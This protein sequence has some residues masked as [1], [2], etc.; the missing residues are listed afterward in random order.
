MTDEKA[1]KI[2]NFINMVDSLSNLKIKSNGRI[3]KLFELVNT[4]INQL[5]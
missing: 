1:E 2:Q 3:F 5:M 4:S